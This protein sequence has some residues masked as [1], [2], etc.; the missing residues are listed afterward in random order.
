[1]WNIAYQFGLNDAIAPSL[2]NNALIIL[3][4]ENGRDDAIWDEVSKRTFTNEEHTKLADLVLS[5]RTRE[6]FTFFGR[7]KD[8]LVNQLNAQKLSPQSLNDLRL[9]YWVPEV[10]LP[11]KIIAG[12][13][14]SVIVQGQSFPVMNGPLVGTV[15]C[16]EGVSIDDGSYQG[17]EERGIWTL[18]ASVNRNQ[19][20]SRFNTTITIDTPGTHTI[21]V[22]YWL[23]DRRFERF[24]D[25]LPRDEENRLTLPPDSTWMIPVTIDTEVTVQN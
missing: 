19:S 1:L 6:T 11:E 17:Q 12:K 18:E 25:L 16:Y 14:F 9:T 13:P 15:I 7:S 2:T 22:K 4:A 23:M 3:A 8:W 24:N 21:R 10:I 5:N 20:Y